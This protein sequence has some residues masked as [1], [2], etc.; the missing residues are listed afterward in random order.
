MSRVGI[1]AFTELNMVTRDVIRPFVTSVVFLDLLL[2]PI[3][4][5]DETNRP[6]EESSY[7]IKRVD[8]KRFRRC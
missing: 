4:N 3:E 6:N 7:W 1:L 2:L 8:D 5:E